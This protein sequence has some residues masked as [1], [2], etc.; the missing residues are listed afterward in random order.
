MENKKYRVDVTDECYDSL[1]IHL[2]F[3]ASVSIEAAKVFREAFFELLEKLEDFPEANIAVSL[4]SR[5]D[6]IYRRAVLGK[7]H[8]VLYEVHGQAVSVDMVLDLRHS[9][10]YTYDPARL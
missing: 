10:E 8:A 3:I 6:I 2:Q 5:P 9:Q 1:K 4:K 7:Y